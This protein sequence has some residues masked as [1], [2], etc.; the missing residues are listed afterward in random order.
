MLGLQQSFLSKDGSDYGD[1][2]DFRGRK[3]SN[4]TDESIIVPIARLCKK[5]CGKELKLSYPYARKPRQNSGA[6]FMTGSR[7]DAES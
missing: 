5:N 3:R 2:N 4:K 1:G 6:K 7:H